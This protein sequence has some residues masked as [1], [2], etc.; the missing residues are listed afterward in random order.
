MKGRVYLNGEGVG[1]GTHLSLF[2]VIMKGDYDPF[3]P[4]PFRNKVTM[5]LLDQSG[6]QHAVDALRPDP[7][8]R[9][10]R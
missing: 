10:F 2:F 6:N 9:S 8:S 3:L 5:M 7:N 4:W 1:K